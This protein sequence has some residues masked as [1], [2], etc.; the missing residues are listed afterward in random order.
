M[1]YIEINP[2][3]T[4]VV[5]HP[6]DYQWSSYQSNTQQSENQLFQKHSAYIQLGLTEEQ[7]KSRFR[8][9][10]R[11]YLDKDTI[12]QIRNALNLKLVLGRSYFKDKIEAM[13]K[14]PARLGKPGRPRVAEENAGYVVFG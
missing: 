3:R 6:G 11:D 10:F 4:A 2:V 13:T 12:H 1:R 5:E 9:L 8:E 7:R 14:R